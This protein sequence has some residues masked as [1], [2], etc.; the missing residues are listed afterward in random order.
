M[1]KK[2]TLLITTCV[3]IIFTLP[4]HAQVNFGTSLHNT[5][6]GK[7]FWYNADTSQT[8]APAPGFESLTNVP[9]THENVACKL[10]HP[11]DNLDANGD[12]YPTPY[13]GAACIDCH[14]SKA[15]F[16]VT[17]ADCYGCHGRQATE[18][19]KLG[20]SDVHRDAS[21]PLKCWDCHK[22][23][24][25]HGD[26]GVAYNS[27][28]EPGAIKTDCGDCHT[29]AG[30]TLPDH[31]A[32]DPH[33]GNLHCDACHSQSVVSCYNCHFES[34][35][36]SHVKRAKQPIHGFVLLVNREKDG[37]VGTASFQSLS[38]QG[39]T[40]AAFAPYHSHTVTDKGRTCTDCH[41]NQ[42]G[43]VEAIK[44]YNAAGEVKFAS[45]NSA[46]SILSWVKGIIPF[47]ADYETSFKMDFITYNGNTSDP[48]TPSKNW[49]AIGKDSWDG[50]QLFFATPLSKT[51]MAKLG[52]GTTANFSTSLHAT[53][54]GKNYW[55]GADN[56]STGAPAPGFESLTNV[57]IDH[58]NVACVL[59]HPGDN[60]DANG[61]AYPSP[62][63]GANCVDCHATK[64]GMAVSEADCYGCHG[65]QATE[66]NTL[67]YSDVHRDA[68]NPLKCWDCHSKAELHGDDGADYN[69]MLEPGAIKTDCG[70][71]HTTV[72]GTLPDHSSYDPHGDKL[73]CDACHSQTVVSCYNCHF[74]SQVES[75]VK[76]AKQ[77][78]HNFVM[79]VN[80][81]KDGKVGTASFQ[82]L[83][84]QGNTWAAFA[85]YHSHTVTDKGRICSD[86]HNNMGSGGIEAI[87]QYNQTGE[88][89]F[90]SWSSSDST[91]NWLK[92][93][94]PFPEDYQT[95]FKMDFITYNGNTSDPP[96]P[97][98]NWSAIGEDTWDGHQLFFAT[99]LSK[100]QM[101]KLGMGGTTN[102]F[103]S[104]HATRVGKNYWYGK[105]TNVTGAPAPGFESLTN[106]PIDHENV[107]CVQCHPADNLDANGDPYPTPYPGASC[108]DCHATNSD[109]KVTEA[110]CYGCHGRQATEKN[111]LGYSDVHRDASTPLK[112]WDCH[113]KDELHGEDGNTYN[114]ILEPGAIK[115]DCEDCHNTG[116][117][118]LPDH[119][120]KDPH[121]DKLHC[122]ACHAQSVISCYNCHFE[123]QVESHVK[124]AK[125]P[126]NDFVILVNRDKDSKV[127]TA[128]FQSLSYQGKTWAAFAP[129]HAHT[130]TG[131]G[132]KCNQ[133]HQ[134][135]GG[136]LEAIQQ[137][138]STGE[139]QFATW[140]SSDST[141]NWVKGIVPFPADYEV[142]F[143]MDF[144]T[145]NG[146]PGDPPNPSKNWSAIG[147]DSW[148]GHQLFFA[149]AL[150]AEQMTKLGMNLPSA[151][152]SDKR[153]GRIPESFALYQNYPN[154]FNPQTTIAFDLK[155]FSL[156]KLKLF[157]I[158]GQEVKTILEAP[159]SAGHH[160]IVFD[161]QDLPSGIYMY[162][163]TAGNFKASRKLVLM[164]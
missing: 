52:M 25:L 154:P 125:Q 36:E 24:E 18:K 163:I 41:Q 33:D 143:K 94:V 159:M 49:S 140:N 142:A 28:L 82:S 161:A 72:G 126:I 106:V 66:K 132:R 131:E 89:E 153:T 80:R 133:C 44:Q 3:I 81:E 75:H 10:C 152:D 151:V 1:K 6:L 104:L 56:A 139:I 71:C 30:G 164:K 16:V 150:T 50:H 74:E 23:E 21:T 87:E 144:I 99:P 8:Y 123:S 20:Y 46:D 60:L 148:D 156:V 135:F 11:A 101:A 129:Y 13:P 117:G 35:V 112:C 34:Q 90:A 32:Y 43:D 84:Y 124:R 130:I 59:C 64:S 155:K 31:S 9:I 147:K 134:N 62:Y 105:D 118:T 138:N 127:G 85:P 146:N 88:I 116:A 79:L 162:Q 63:P 120:G 47:P 107:A 115:T 158:N 114:S 91:L 42:G 2:L 77:P 4:L 70:D 157:N 29:T 48:A 108:A 145:Y 38:Y 97:S 122:D 111:K 83:S 95:S 68:S 37:K 93:V 136:Q 58:E 27:M 26:D 73:H 51:Q 113:Q 92:G 102:F 76:R 22:K 121:G 98:K 67:G 5:R 54:K 61:E 39:N 137:Y 160:K 57:P 15:G 96:G 110:D 45:W 7:G 78:I 14:A 109:M 119:T 53:R 65:R 86:C 141:L 128:T 17:E 103:N 55:Y 40:W 12:P 100:S 19:N 149:T 69:S